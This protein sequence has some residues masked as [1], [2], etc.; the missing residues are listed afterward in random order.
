MKYA[1]KGSAAEGVTLSGAL[2]WAG[3]CMDSAP[4]KSSNGCRRCKAKAN[5]S[6]KRTEKNT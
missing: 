4:E 2:N 5:L 3:L 1:G 6:G